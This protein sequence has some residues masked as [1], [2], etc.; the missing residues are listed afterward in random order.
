MKMLLCYFVTS[1]DPTVSSL[2]NKVIIN[3][4]LLYICHLIFLANSRTNESFCQVSI[5]CKGK[6]L[7]VAKT[8][9]EQSNKGTFCQRREKSNRKTP[10]NPS[11]QSNQ[12][13]RVLL[14]KST[15]S[16][17]KVNTLKSGYESKGFG[18]QPFLCKIIVTSFL[19]LWLS[20]FNYN[21]YLCPSNTVLL[22]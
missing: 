9:K 2:L 3:S 17:C 6:N 16:S 8:T 12:T 21:S 11:N 4:A 18:G 5:Y 15:R 19:P 14:A 13:Q 22:V 7:R 20:G 10:S 1:E